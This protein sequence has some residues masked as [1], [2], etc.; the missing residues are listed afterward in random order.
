MSRCSVTVSTTTGMANERGACAD[1]SHDIAAALV[2][3]GGENTP[4]GVCENCEDFCF[5][6]EYCESHCT[7]DDSPGYN[8]SGSG[9]KDDDDTHDDNDDHYLDEGET[10]PFFHEGSLEKIAEITGID[11]RRVLSLLKNKMGFMFKPWFILFG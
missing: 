4:C 6:C 7:C 2:C 5:D 9:G 10:I 1:V 11:S 3:E 8:G